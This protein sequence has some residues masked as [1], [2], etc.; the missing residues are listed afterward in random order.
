[1]FGGTLMRQHAV[2]VDVDSN[3]MGFARATCASDPLQ[4]MNEE[5]LLSAH[6]FTA[7]DAS[8]VETVEDAECDHKVDTGNWWRPA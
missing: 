6:Q 7:L 2:I 3:R 5:T 1:M 4:I 8:Y